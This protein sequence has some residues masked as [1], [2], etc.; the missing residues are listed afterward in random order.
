MRRITTR[1]SLGIAKAVE[2]REAFKTRGALAGHALA[3]S[4]RVTFR[5][6]RLPRAHSDALDTATRDGR[7]RYV[8]SSYGTPIAWQYING[9]WSVPSARYSVTTSRHQYVAR[10]AVALLTK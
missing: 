8:I 4:E 6:G 9:V 1:D 3:D 10:L 5:H 2:A 7:I